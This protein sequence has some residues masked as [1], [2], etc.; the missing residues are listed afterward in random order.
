MNVEPFL[1]ETFVS[2]YF[3]LRL[4][5]RL[6]PLHSSVWTFLDFRGFPFG[7]FFFRVW[8]DG[9]RNVSRP[10]NSLLWSLNHNRE[11]EPPGSDLSGKGVDIMSDW[12]RASSEESKSTT[13]SNIQWKKSLGGDYGL[14][15][16]SRH[17]GVTRWRLGG[18]GMDRRFIWLTDSPG[19]RTHPPLLVIGHSNEVNFGKVQPVPKGVNVL[20]PCRWVTWNGSLPQQGVI[21]FIGVGSWQIHHEFGVWDP[22]QTF[23]S[24]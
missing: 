22:R 20:R 11:G 4:S 17:K 24:F 6:Y 14:V 7:S 12:G 18:T 10:K 8:K 16:F 21:S 15:S 2:R 13:V 3:F 23:H 5:S 9:R 1:S 19:P